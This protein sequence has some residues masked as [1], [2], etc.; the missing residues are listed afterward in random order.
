MSLPRNIRQDLELIEAAPFEDGSPRWRLHDPAAN[1]FYDLGYLEVEILRELRA[2]PSLDIDSATLA[3][4]IAER[5][6]V[7]CSSRQIEEFVSFLQDN[8]L[9]W[10]EGERALERRKTLRTPRWKTLALR[11]WRQYLF[12]RIPILHPDGLLD[13]ILPWVGWAFRP[14]SWWVL[15]AIGVLAIYLTSRQVDYFLSTF[16]GYFTPVGLV[17][18]GIAVILA[19]ILHEFGH[20]LTAR[21]YGC[22]VRA[23]G[24]AFLVFWPILYTDTTD[25]WRLRSRRKRVLIGAA[26]MLVEIGLA[27]VCLLLWNFTPEG[28]FKNILFMMSTTTWI[29]TLLINL[30]PL[31]R[32][33]GYYILSDLTGVENLQERSNAM[34]RWRLREWLFGYGRP[35]PEQGLRWL[36]PFSYAVWVYRLFIFFGIT[37]IV[38]TYF[39]KALGVV[40]AAAQVVRLLAMPIG[41]EMGHWWES[42][43][44]GNTRYLR[45]SA[46]AVLILLAAVMAPIDRELELPAYWQA[47]SVVTF[48]APIPGQ[49]SVLP[50]PGSDMVAAGEPVAV[51]TSPDLEFQLE[52]ANHDLRSSRYQL[53]RTSF[54]AGLAQERL[55]LQAKLQGALETQENLQAQLDDARLVAPFTGRIS[56]RQADLRLGDWVSRGDRL[57]TLVDDTAGEVVAYLSE[58]E[59]R[60]LREGATGRFYPEGGVRAPQPVRLVDVDGFSLEALETAYVASTYGGG[61]DV[62]DGT[63]G[64]LIPQRATYRIYL[65]T[66]SPADDRVLRGQLVLD[67]EARSLAGMVWRQVV[68]VWR[69]EAGI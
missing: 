33:D 26:G 60:A 57:L 61:L 14:R 32:F 3:K 11:I 66:E 37:Y 45:R 56:D 34:G 19:K 41:R 24:V 8:D 25:A 23:M 15:T 55:S 58:S 2:E 27:A 21:R 42:R 12:M 44:E 36:V 51:I 7:I 46:I 47:R 6:Q 10:I 62:R 16:V 28:F 18:F 68:G 4:T 20:A 64:E 30:N 52:Q 53:E 59:L 35:A 1:R 69:R 54:G 13:R 40:L 67:A 17:Y 39:F 31:M 5:A 48:Y 38:Y 63:D 29:M 9:Y 43:A 50:S 22:S 65:E 49:L